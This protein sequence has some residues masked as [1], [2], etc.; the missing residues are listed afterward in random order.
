MSI[1]IA[2]PSVVVGCAAVLVAAAA[3][4]PAAAAKDLSDRSVRVLM[5]Y[6]W[7]L[8]PQKFRTPDGKTIEVDRTKKSDVVVPLDTAREVIRVARLSAHAQMCDLPEEQVANYQTL[9]RREAAKKKWTEQQLLY[10]N[11]LHLFT[12]MW[13]TGKVKLVERD[14]KEGQQQTPDKEVVV[15][16]NAPGKVETCS[17]AQKDKVKEQI[18]AYLKLEPAA[19]TPTAAKK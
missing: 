13:L 19:A 8:V 15:E 7:A 17:P 2:R 4:V 18:S 11:Q 5:D 6:A 16:D 9:M 1:R 10:I 14:S 12:V 3:A